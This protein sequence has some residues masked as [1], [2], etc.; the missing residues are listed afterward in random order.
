MATAY[1][2]ATFTAKSSTGADGAIQAQFNSPGDGSVSVLAG[3]VLVAYDVAL[4][5]NQLRQALRGFLQ[6]L[7]SAS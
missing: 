6:S 2:T 1:M 7:G 3:N 5:N 4:T